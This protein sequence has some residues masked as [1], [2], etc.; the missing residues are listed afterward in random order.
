MKTAV[1]PRYTVEHDDIF[2]DVSIPPG[3]EYLRDL[4]AALL[5]HGS[6]TFLFESMESVHDYSGDHENTREVTQIPRKLL[7]SLSL[8]RHLSQENWFADG[9]NV[10]LA[11]P[12]V[13]NFLI[14]EGFGQS[15]CSGLGSVWE[16]IDS[17]K[18]RLFSISVRH[19]EWHSD[20][21]FWSWVFTIQPLVFTD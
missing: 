9:R 18:S 15:P 13:G 6:Q 10:L 12:S 5:I 19:L 7:L 20:D 1:G 21:S 8:R 4:H 14:R 16:F 11:V 2:N 17:V 3:T